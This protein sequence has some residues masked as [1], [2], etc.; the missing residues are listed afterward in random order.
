M[1]QDAP[2]RFSNSWVQ[3]GVNAHSYF[4]H[5]PTISAFQGKRLSFLRE[6]SAFFGER[7]NSILGIENVQ[8]WNILLFWDLTWYRI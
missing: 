6:P 1:R 2:T 8:D 7:R 5:V 3:A 4:Q